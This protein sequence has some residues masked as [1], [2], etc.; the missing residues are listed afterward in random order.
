[1]ADQQW[2]HP[3]GPWNDENRVRR[4]QNSQFLKTSN[5]NIIIVFVPFIKMFANLVTHY[6]NF[7]STYLKL[8]IIFQLS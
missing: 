4:D 1:M 5:D 7:L 2:R 8:L 3:A 6:H